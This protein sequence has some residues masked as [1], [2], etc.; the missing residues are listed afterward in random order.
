MWGSLE[1]KQL[2]SVDGAQL[3]VTRNLHAALLRLR[4]PALDRILWVDAIC[5]NQQD[6]K[7]RAEQVQFMAM[8]YVCASRVLVWL[9]EEAQGS[10]EAM[11]RIEFE[12]YNDLRY[13]KGL[14]DNGINAKDVQSH[15]SGNRPKIAIHTDNYDSHSVGWGLNGRSN[16]DDAMLQGYQ[17]GEGDATQRG[18]ESGGLQPDDHVLELLQR[19]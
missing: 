8:V 3:S 19:P 11:K 16:A 6:L 12:A 1:N 4:D 17:K 13:Q 9:G 18:G 7:E 14:R 15:T 2:T 10:I 5:I